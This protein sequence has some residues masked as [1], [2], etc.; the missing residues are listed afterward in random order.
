LTRADWAFAGFACAFFAIGFGF[1]AFAFS[2]LTL[3]QRAFAAA[4]FSLFPRPRVCVS[5]VAPPPSSRGQ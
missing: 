4:L 1:E 3:T 5:F 2:F